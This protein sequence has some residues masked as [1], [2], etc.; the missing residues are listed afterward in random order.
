MKAVE[1]LNETLYSKIF[2]DG[3]FPLED[4]VLTYKIYFQLL[5]LKEYNLIK[6]KYEFWKFACD[7]FTKDS[8]I[9]LGQI[10]QNLLKKFDFSNAN[11]YRLSRLLGNNFSKITPN[12]FSKLCGTTGL[13]IFLIKDALEYAGILVDKKTSPSRLNKNFTYLLEL[14]QTKKERLKIIQSKCLN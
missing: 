2:T 5:N 1:L 7:F 10:I 13:F 6:D 8:T 12:Y 9:K 14:L 11:V 3:P 4:I